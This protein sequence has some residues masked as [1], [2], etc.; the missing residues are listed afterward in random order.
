[1]QSGEVL[2]RVFLDHPEGQRKQRRVPKVLAKSTV[3]TSD[4][5][6]QISLRFKES[7]EAFQ[8]FLSL[9]FVYF[10]MRVFELDTC[11]PHEFG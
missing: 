1:M 8:Y 3:G 4:V 6:V 7:L 5:L 11:L 2:R 9:L 10:R